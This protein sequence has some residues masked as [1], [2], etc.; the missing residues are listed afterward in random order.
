MLEEFATL[1][2]IN[3]LPLIWTTIEPGRFTIVSPWA[4]KGTLTSYIDNMR[5]RLTDV[6][7]L[8]LVRVSTLTLFARVECSSL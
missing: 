5:G 2:H 6:Q 4:E 7:I 8:T 1:D 3:V